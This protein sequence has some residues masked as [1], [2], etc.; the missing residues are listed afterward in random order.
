MMFEALVV[1]CVS[2]A[3]QECA[4]VEDTRGPYITARECADRVVEMSADIRKI[5]NRY[6]IPTGRCEPVDDPERQFSAT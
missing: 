4:I 3:Q 5:D 2:M 6:V 1:V